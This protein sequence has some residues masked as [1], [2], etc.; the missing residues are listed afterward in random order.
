MGGGASPS[1]HYFIKEDKQMKVF[2]DYTTSM[3]LP[4]EIPDEKFNTMTQADFRDL[5]DKI[6]LKKHLNEMQILTESVSLLDEDGDTLYFTK[7]SN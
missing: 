5:A 3:T 6:V 7:Y 2:L 1:R 4:L